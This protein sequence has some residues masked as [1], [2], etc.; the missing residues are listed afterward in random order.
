[1]MKEAWKRSFERL[2]ALDLG[3]DQSI[4]QPGRD[5]CASG[6]TVVESKRFEKRQA[7]AFVDGEDK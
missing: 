3:D 7:Q 4:S 2:A 5:C 6:H 1:M